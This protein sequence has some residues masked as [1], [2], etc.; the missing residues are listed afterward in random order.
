MSGSARDRADEE[1]RQILVAK[2]AAYESKLAEQQ[3]AA[4]SA[5]V[6]VRPNSQGMTNVSMP[7]LSQRQK[8]TLRE[9]AAN[10]ETLA[11]PIQ[12]A[13]GS[14]GGNNPGNVATGRVRDRIERQ[15]EL[16]QTTP[17]PVDTTWF[18]YEK[19]REAEEKVKTAAKLKAQQEADA[20]QTAAQ[21]AAGERQLWLIGVEDALSAIQATPEE[22]QRAL[23]SSA[24]KVGDDPNK[25]AGIVL[26]LRS[27]R[28]GAKKWKL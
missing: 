4:E 16:A 2:G 11:A 25:V 1:A 5:P 13:P 14:T 17:T 27:C 10:P 26:T 18:E 22:R 15:V 19:N 28:A 3:A 6:T 12:R 20:Q 23:N 8:A 7:A 9:E 21:K 24:V